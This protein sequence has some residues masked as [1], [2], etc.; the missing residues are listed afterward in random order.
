MPKKSINVEPISKSYQHISKQFSIKLVDTKL[1][2][3]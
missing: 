3:N 2:S 1:I